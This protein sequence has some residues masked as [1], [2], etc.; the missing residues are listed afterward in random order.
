MLMRGIHTVAA[1]YSQLLFLF[2]VSDRYARSSLSKER[3]TRLLSFLSVGPQRVRTKK[4]LTEIKGLISSYR[5]KRFKKR[6]KRC[7]YGYVAYHKAIIVW[8]FS[9]KKSAKAIEQTL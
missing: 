9:S 2:P 7:E 5:C 1:G 6:R 4:I 3:Y 8:K